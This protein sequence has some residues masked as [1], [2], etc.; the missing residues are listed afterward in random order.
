[1]KIEI[2]PLQEEEKE[3]EELQLKVKST[4]APKWNRYAN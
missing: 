1:M 4:K 2:P 3:E